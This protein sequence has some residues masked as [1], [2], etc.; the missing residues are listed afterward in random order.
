[1]ETFKTINRLFIDTNRLIDMVHDG[2]WNNDNNMNFDQADT[3]KN[4]Y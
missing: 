1:M 4:C 3:N 2:I